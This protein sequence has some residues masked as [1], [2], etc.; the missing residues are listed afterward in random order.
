MPSMALMGLQVLYHLI[1]K[2]TYEVVT[3]II[4]IFTYRKMR[5]LEQLTESVTG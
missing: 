3:I 5:Q 1:F 4:P 2:Q